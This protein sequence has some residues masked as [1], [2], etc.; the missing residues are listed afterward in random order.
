VIDEPLASAQ[1]AHAI[2]PEQHRDRAA[3]GGRAA[4]PAGQGADLLARRLAVVAVADDH[5][6]RL[7]LAAELR[8]PARAID[9]MSGFSRDHG[10][11]PSTDRAEARV[12]LSGR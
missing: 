11:S 2:L 6:Q 1:E 12:S 7:A 5:G 8:L 9:M 3:V 10:F 4:M